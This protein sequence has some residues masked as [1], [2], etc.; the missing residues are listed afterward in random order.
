MSFETKIES[1][2][3]TT[4]PHAFNSLSNIA[5]PSGVAFGWKGM[6]K[7]KELDLGQTTK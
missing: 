4:S 1:P 7:K 6:I 5:C 2:S 3:H